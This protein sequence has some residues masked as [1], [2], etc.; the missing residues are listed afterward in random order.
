[1]NT[2]N[3]IF[4]FALPIL[5][6]IFA[7]SEEQY[8]KI[9]ILSILII[10]V[11]SINILN[12]KPSIE[13]LSLR[14]TQKEV[15][16]LFIVIL[17]ISISSAISGSRAEASISRGV[18]AL[19]AFIIIIQ[20]IYQADEK[21]R[22]LSVKAFAFGITI[23]NN[24]NIVLY[25]V[26]IVNTPVVSMPA[27]I[28]QFFG[29]DTERVFFKL[30][31]GINSYG[32][33]CIICFLLAIH[34]FKFGMGVLI[35]FYAVISIIFAVTAVLLIDSRGAILSVI[36]AFVILKIL[37]YFPRKSLFVLTFVL[38]PSLLSL[39]HLVMPLLEFIPSRGYFDDGQTLSGRILFWDQLSLYFLDASFG[40]ILLGSNMFVVPA[41]LVDTFYNNDF[42]VDANFISVHSSLRQALL[43]GG[44]VLVASLYI[45][46]IG[47][48]AK[49][50]AFLKQDKTSIHL[51]MLSLGILINANTESLLTASN[52]FFGPIII[53]L[54]LPSLIYKGKK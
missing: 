16:L 21:S 33:V 12:R 53:S 5:I 13:I 38:V 1:M 9:F 14:Q 29:I 17:I 50:F 32:I 43:E 31:V 42:Q 2:V 49:S 44:V 35:K 39:P 4:L 46:F 24:A 37:Q 36:C 34:L 51:P 15:Y 27:T 28:I 54:I 23:L 41:Q 8:I 22:N 45:I 30:S 20:I 7:I 52:I 11:V 3:N 18:F 25:F 48:G 40:N 47:I 10:Y 26:G 6:A 19:V